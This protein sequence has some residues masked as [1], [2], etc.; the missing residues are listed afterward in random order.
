MSLQAVLVDIKPLLQVATGQIYPRIGQQSPRWRS[1]TP[2]AYPLPS[3]QSQSQAWILAICRKLPGRRERY[4][5]HTVHRCPLLNSQLSQKL[6]NDSEQFVAE[7][8]SARCLDLVQNLL[9]MIMSNWNG[10]MLNKGRPSLQPS[11][12]KPVLTSYPAG[13]GWR[14]AV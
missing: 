11:T 13:R 12:T 6:A 9:I 1:W 5:Y 10:C 7:L 14:G 4:H 2:Q 8:V 3:Y